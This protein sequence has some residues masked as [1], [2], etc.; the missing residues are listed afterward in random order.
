[1]R[2]FSKVSDRG[3]STGQVMTAHQVMV[4]RGIGY[5]DDTPRADQAFLSSCQRE[6]DP[7]LHLVST[8]AHH[9]SRVRRN[10]SNLPEPR[11]LQ[12]ACAR[13]HD[14]EHGQIRLMPWLCSSLMKASNSS[15]AVVSRKFIEAA[16][17][18]T[19]V[20]CGRHVVSAFFNASIERPM[21]AKNRSPPTRHISSPGNVPASG[22]RW[23]P[24]ETQ[25]K[26]AGSG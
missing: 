10:Y 19:C 11:Y 8:R 25:M 2:R 4:C 21:L 17:T 14:R 12:A 5:R 6:D 20:G 13:A 15:Q 24:D 26:G 7:A 22:W 18:S 23:A 9:R 1:M 16:S 3:A